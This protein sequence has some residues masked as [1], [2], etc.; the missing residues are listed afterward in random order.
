MTANTSTSPVSIL[1]GLSQRGSV[2]SRRRRDFLR[3]LQYDVEALASELEAEGFSPDEAH[4]RACTLILPDGESLERWSDVHAS[5]YSRLSALLDERR[6]R[7]TERGVFTAVVAVAG[8]MGAAVV[9]RAELLSDPSPFLW[10]VLA[11]GIL[12]FATCLHHAALL[13]G[14]GQTGRAARTLWWILFLSAAAFTIAAVGCLADL[15]TLLGRLQQ[16]PANA[17]PE[18]I[19]AIRRDGALLA[20]ALIQAMAGAVFWLIATQWIAV[21]HDALTRAFLETRSTILKEDTK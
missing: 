14:R 20:I 1:E 15:V 21:T 18:F 17:A 8:A 2:S 3:E 10:P 4:S 16:S 12:I 6:L 13:W 19:G 11:C 5:P 7:R 9:V